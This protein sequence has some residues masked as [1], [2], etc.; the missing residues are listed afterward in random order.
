M[1]TATFG[2]FSLLLTISFGY[3]LGDIWKADKLIAAVLSVVGLIVVTPQSFKQLISATGTESVMVNG[4]IRIGYFGTGAVMTTLLLTTAIVWLFAKMSSNKS[5][6]I[7]MPE[8]VPESVARSFQ[9]LI[10]ITI[11]LFFIALFASILHWMEQPAFNDLI[12]AI[13]QAPLMGFSQGIGFAL[14]Y[15]FI[16]WFFWWFGIHGHNVTAVIQNSVYF[17]AQLANQD[18]SAA[19]IFSNGFFEAGLMHI[20]GLVI[21]I[22]I[23]SKRD[24]WRA[25]VKIGLPSMMFN[26]QEPLA[27]GIPIVLNPLLI[28]PYII[29]PLANTL[30]G[31]AAISLQ[32]VPIFKFVVPWTM[33]LFFGGMIGTGSISGG[34]L[35]LVFL[36]ADIMIY[37]P[38]VI[39]GNKVKDNV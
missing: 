12:Y 19:Y 35:Q 33:P 24:D 20:M 10:P 39:I 4:A 15:Q 22:L 36:L 5:L 30:I 28:I 31:W 32:L 25:V 3:R 29:A 26:I 27:F 6:V 11:T 23:F 18:G 37:A 9:A 34:L 13:I 14:L 17:P 38:F 8:S 21:A 16:I 7:R 1:V 2:I